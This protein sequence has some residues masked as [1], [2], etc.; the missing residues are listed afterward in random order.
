MSC[1]RFS[2][3]FVA[4]TNCPQGVYGN[5]SA[6]LPLPGTYLFLISKNAPP[7]SVNSWKTRGGNA[8]PESSPPCGVRIVEA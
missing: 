6:G 5:L 1:N 4:P 3:G 7:P 2:R 8:F